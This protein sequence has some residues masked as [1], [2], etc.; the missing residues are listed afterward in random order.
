MRLEELEA[1]IET[2]QEEVNEPNFL[3]KSCRADTTS[4][5]KLSAAEQEL[6]VAFESLGSRLEALTN[7]KR[8]NVTELDVD[9]VVV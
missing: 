2:L 7:E 1:Q 3:L 5:D 8:K 9:R 4:L 6:E